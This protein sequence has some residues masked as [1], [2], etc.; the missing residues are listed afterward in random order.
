MGTGWVLEDFVVFGWD[1]VEISLEIRI[2]VKS[3]VC[4]DENN[5]IE[6]LD[7]CCMDVISRGDFDVGTGWVLGDFVVFGWDPVEISL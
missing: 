3:R 7:A 5:T 1:L 6:P 4:Q 2:E